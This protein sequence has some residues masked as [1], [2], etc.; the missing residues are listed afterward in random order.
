MLSLG[1]SRGEA[2]ETA[3]VR[4][5]AAAWQRSG[6]VL[7]GLGPAARHISDRSPAEAGRVRLWEAF[8]QQLRDTGYGEGH[9]VLFEPR[10]A[11]GQADRLPALAKEL[12]DL[13]VDLIVTA[14]TPA[15]VAAQHVYANYSGISAKKASSKGSMMPENHCPQPTQNNV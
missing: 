1:L 8:R 9:N 11:D 10:W 14:G 15:V 3:R 4:Q 7:S 13:R 6:V 2:D 12:V 5:A